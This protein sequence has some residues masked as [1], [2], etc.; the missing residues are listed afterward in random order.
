MENSE[1]LNELFGALSKAQGEMNSA[2]KDTKNLFFKSNYADLA[3]CWDAIREPFS[4]HGLSIIQ[5]PM[6][7]KDFTAKS[8]Y[9]DKGGNVKYFDISGQTVV[10]KTLLCHSSGQYMS[11]II[12]LQPTKV[13]PQG[14]GS[15]LTYARRYGLM[16]MSGIAPEEDDGNAASNNNQQPYAP[17]AAT[18]AKAAPK[19]PAPAVNKENKKVTVA[20]LKRLHVISQQV[21]W[22]AECMSSLMLYKFEVK[23]GLDLNMK[24]YDEIIDYIQNNTFEEFSQTNGGKK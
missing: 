3:S 22:P 1:Q 20:Q 16:A 17:K 9:K 11:S 7:G 12:E 24:Q 2:K 18:P 15:A 10:I 14:M 6:P 19:A 5:M 4:K 8:S 13:D 21:D 23:S